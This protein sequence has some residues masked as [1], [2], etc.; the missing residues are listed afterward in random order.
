MQYPSLIVHSADSATHRVATVEL[1][2]APEYSKYTKAGGTAPGLSQLPL[3]ARTSARHNGRIGLVVYN[4]RRPTA[5]RM[6]NLKGQ[7]RSGQV[8]YSVEV[9]DHEGQVKNVRELTERRCPNEQRA[10]ER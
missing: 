3:H 10:R 8:Y 7:V 4:Y 2:S 9:Q 5:S 6:S 1:P